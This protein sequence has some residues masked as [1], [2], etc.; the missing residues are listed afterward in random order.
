[1]IDVIRDRL[2]EYATS[3]ALEAENALK[4]IL[5]EIALYALWRGRLARR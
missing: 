4:E 1:M 2:R 3:N 5:Q